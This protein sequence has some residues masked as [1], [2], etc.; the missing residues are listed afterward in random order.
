ME[1]TKL[2][3]NKILLSNRLK[4]DKREERREKRE[5]TKDTHIVSIHYS[6]FIYG[7]R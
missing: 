3:Y 1:R 2:F 4:R 5:E 7:F 6:Y